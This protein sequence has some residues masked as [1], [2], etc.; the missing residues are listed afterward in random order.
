MRLIGM[1]SSGIIE[2]HTHPNAAELN[3]IINGKA[4]CTVFSPNGEVETSEIGQVQ[5]FFVL[6]GYFHYLENS[7]NVF[8]CN[9]ASFFGNE[10]PEFL[11]L[12]GALSAYSNEVLGSVFNKDP[13]FFTKLPRLQKN[14]LIASGTG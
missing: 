10:N 9:F 7:D 5:A 11:G 2:P 12:S 1:K 13:K 4:R 3:Y 6:A 8:C 14:V